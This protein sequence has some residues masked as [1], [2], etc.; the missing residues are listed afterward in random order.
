[1]SISTQIREKVKNTIKEYDM[2]EKGDKVLVALSG[3]ADSVCLTHILSALSK[4]MK[5]S[6]YAAHL[7]HGIRGEEADRDENFAK[8]FCQS[9]DVPFL[10]K[11]VKAEEIAKAEGLT[12]EE[13]GRRERYAFFREVCKMGGQRVIATAHNRDDAAETVLMRIIRGTGTDGLS[14]IKFVREDGVVRPL[15]RISRKE[16]EEYCTENGLKYCTDSTNADNDYTRNRIRN[17]LLPYIR[18]NFNPNINESLINLSDSA[19]AD[20]DFLN[21]YAKRLYKSLGSPMPNRKPVVLHIESMEM[22]D[23][24]IMSRLII[25]AAKEAM[26][27]GFYLE[28]KHIRDILALKDKKTG[29]MLNFPKGL[30]VCVK[31]G[32]LEFKNEN[33]TKMQSASK[34]FGNDYMTEIEPGNGYKIEGQSG[35]VFV[36]RVIL[37]EY[38]KSAGDILID[39]D[40]LSGTVVLRNRRE[41]DRMA[42][43][44]DGRSRKIKSIF[45]DMKIPREKRDDIPLIC[46]GNE[47]IAIVG[48]R[49]S[50]KYKTDK[51]SERA[52]V[53]YYGNDGQ[54]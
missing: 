23:S 7:N 44:E 31:Y 34:Y 15:L 20:S 49:V 9:L 11:T 2:I 1:M 25:A 4:E 40:K 28:K 32:W 21:S 5:F 16:I 26:G 13:A 10:S 27:E 37:S 14:G 12:V 43:F 24:A 36:K 39:E 41:G 38:K 17:E 19:K 8:E 45:I 54:G 33:E 3:G 51:N 35:T 46:T 50:E 48:G 53:I 22:V 30:S 47:V 6:L 29:A 18:E 42:V 52:W